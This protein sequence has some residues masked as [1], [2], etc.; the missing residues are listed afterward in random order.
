MLTYFRPSGLTQLSRGIFDFSCGA[1]LSVPVDITEQADRFVLTA[2]LPGMSEKDID[3]NV[4]DGML[5]LSGEREKSSEKHD[6]ASWHRERWSGRF[7]RRFTLGSS[8]DA[9]KIEAK[10][11]DGVLT[12]TLPKKR[13]KQPRQIPVRAN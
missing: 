10:Y 4:H 7:V 5:T 1:P 3:V 12:L 9:G 13:E 6:K 11:K 8:V 2:D